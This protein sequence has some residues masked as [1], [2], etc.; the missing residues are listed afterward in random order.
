MKIEQVITGFEKRAGIKTAAAMKAITKQLSRHTSST[1]A[2]AP[3][4]AQYLHGRYREKK[5][6]SM[7]SGFNA[8]A[9]DVHKIRNII[10]TGVRRGTM[11][12]P[13]Y[14]TDD[15]IKEIADENINNHIY[16]MKQR[17]NESEEQSLNPDSRLKKSIVPGVLAGLIGGGGMMLADTNNPLKSPLKSALIGAAIGGLGAGGLRAAFHN[18][19]KHQEMHK[20]LLPKRKKELKDFTKD[21]ALK[22]TVSDITNRLY[23]RDYFSEKTASRAATAKGFF[24]KAVNM[25]GVSMQF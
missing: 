18:P 2:L 5:A 8:T 6:S 17:I 15:E 20:K 23:H 21:E 16:W 4:T 19:Q 11:D 12:R 9:A 13:L 25:E 14:L 7:K 1:G 24:R 10:D 3:E 22:E